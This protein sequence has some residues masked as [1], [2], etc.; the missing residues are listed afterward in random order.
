MNT[1]GRC[2]R[3][4]TF[5]ESHGPAIG[6]VV[7]GCPAGLPLSV[8]EIQGELDLRKPGQGELTSPRRESDRVE[9]LSGVFEGRTLGT[10]IALVL[11]N[12]DT[13]PADYN[14][15][16][17]VYRPGHA[18]YT[19][20]MK[21]GLRDHRGGGRSSGR[22]TAAR[23]AAGAVARKF[24]VHEGISVLAFAR[25]IGGVWL[26]GERLEELMAFTGPATGGAAS[27]GTGANALAGLRERV[28]ASPVRCPDP[29]AARAMEE[30]IRAAAAE[31]DSVGGVVEFRAFGVPAGLGDPVF[32][33]LDALLGQAL[34][35]VGA[36]KGVEFGEGF[37]LAAMRGSQA[38]DPFTRTPEGRVVPASNRAGGMLG[39]ISTG[40]PVVGRVA[41]KPTSSIG[42]PQHTVDS[43]GRPVEL[44]IEGRH[45]PCIVV[46]VVPVIEHMVNLV[47][48]D[49]LLSQRGARL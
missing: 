8:E 9:I 1:F 47:L 7:D 40:L 39:G 49:L 22:E 20:Q 6:A 23:V 46:R 24:L 15:L 12:R 10:P 43:S 41:V 34:L 28:Y 29:E 25:M 26:S 18:D 44:S 33:K 13:R 32:G 27:T 21:Y 37:G 5:G 2:F 42:R 11:F 4:T 36:V 48:A 14:R 38:N 31:K 19:Y 16:K 35:S 30:A 45:D 3:V 17:D